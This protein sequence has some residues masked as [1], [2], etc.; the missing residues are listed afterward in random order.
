MRTWSTSI[1]HYRS[2]LCLLYLLWSLS[3]SYSSRP[4]ITP[5]EV[6]LT[7]GPPVCTAP[8]PL[9]SSAAGT[10]EGTDGSQQAASGRTGRLTR[11]AD[12]QS[13][14]VPVTAPFDPTLADLSQRE[15]PASA[16]S[17][18][19]T[20]MPVKGSTSRDVNTSSGWAV[21]P[22]L[23]EK[24]PAVSA[25]V[26][27]DMATSEG[28]RTPLQ[29]SDNAALDAAFDEASAATCASSPEP[30]ASPATPS[31]SLRPRLTPLHVTLL[32]LHLLYAVRLTLHT[33]RNSITTALIANPLP[34]PF[35]SAPTS[36]S[37]AKRIGRLRWRI[38]TIRRR[39][40][41]SILAWLVVTGGLLAFLASAPADTSGAQGWNV[42]ACAGCFGDLRVADGAGA[43]NAGARGWAPLRNVVVLELVST[44]LQA[45][46]AIA[47]LVVSLGWISSSISATFLVPSSAS[48]TS[49]QP[50]P[51]Y[52]L[53]T[54]N[55]L[56]TII[57]PFATNLLTILQVLQ[58]VLARS[59]SQR[60]FSFSTL[61][62]LNAILLPLEELAVVR[63]KKATEAERV[64]KLACA[65][66]RRAA[67]VESASQDSDI[68][69]TCLV[70][71]EGAFEPEG[72]VSGARKVTFTTACELP[73][74]HSFHAACLARW[75]AL[76]STCPAC[77]RSSV[78]PPSTTASDHVSA[79]ATAAEGSSTHE[80][81]SLE[82]PFAGGT[83]ERDTTDE[84]PGAVAMRR[85]EQRR[86][87]AT[88]LE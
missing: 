28:P 74:G 60:W 10:S 12:Q 64:C 17:S 13:Q 6:D 51:S 8:S 71:F 54:D 11:P 57:S 23:S 42:V 65:F 69:A 35:A 88:L 62:V 80:E 83:S 5:S 61:I 82:L 34:P 37:F 24:P 18:S 45:V 19:S 43:V 67:R 59:P 39:C 20:Y 72:T 50:I 29:H 4:A 75:F 27:P 58:L 66:P 31:S 84:Y 49:T 14:T 77:H 7:A 56:S 15:N 85:R 40:G 25:V 30:S 21:T 55:F 46:L 78:S 26:K 81:T 87:Q 73:C 22:S 52:R 38:S 63:E 76:V 44:L 79:D 47:P 48:A 33:V 16:S 41:S 32:Y 70:C 36:A 2:R 9:L 68:D 3:P 1:R 86:A 53:P